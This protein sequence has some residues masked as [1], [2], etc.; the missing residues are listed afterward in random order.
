MNARLAGHGE[1]EGE[2]AVV[3]LAM[4]QYTEQCNDGVM[5]EP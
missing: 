1:W 2:P 5:G 4:N 3:D